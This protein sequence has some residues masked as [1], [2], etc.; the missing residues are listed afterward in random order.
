MSPDEVACEEDESREGVGGD[1]FV[2]GAEVGRGD[3]G[4]EVSFSFDLRPRENIFF[5]RFF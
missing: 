4:G 3:T 2:V 1:E 5:A